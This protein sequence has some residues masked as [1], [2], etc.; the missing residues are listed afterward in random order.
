MRVHIVPA[1]T[2]C[3][4]LG[5]W[6]CGGR[7]VTPP[8]PKPAPVEDPARISW[9]FEPQGIRL[10]LAADSQLNALGDNALALS[11]CVYQLKDQQPFSTI[12]ANQEGLRSFLECELKDPSVVSATHIYVQPGH[13][14][15]RFLD[16]AEGAKY[17]AVVAGYNN[18]VPDRCVAITPMP[19]HSEKSGVIMFRTTSYEAAHMDAFLTV[20][21]D[22]V[23][24]KGAKRAQ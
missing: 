23:N 12:T 4:V 8:M 9:A 21:K 24:L 5:L 13:K 15:T 7:P 3:L 6:G 14:E 1:M 2:L 10:I 20:T 22:A 16:R 17:L 18:L 11:L 19:I